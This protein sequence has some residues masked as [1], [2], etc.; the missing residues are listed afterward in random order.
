MTIDEFKIECD[1]WLNP[2]GWSLHSKS[3]TCLTYSNIDSVVSV[4][5]IID[6]GNNKKIRLSDCISYKYFLKLESGNMQFKHPDFEKIV[7]IFEH[8]SKLAQVY[9]PF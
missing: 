2:L 8:Y 5:C 6:A 9:P 1:E 7:K 3:Q 4:D